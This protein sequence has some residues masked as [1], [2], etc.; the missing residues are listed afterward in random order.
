RASLHHHFTPVRNQ[1]K[2]WSR[3]TKAERTD[4]HRSQQSIG[5]SQGPPLRRTS[6]RWHW[7]LVNKRHEQAR[8]FIVDDGGIE[9]GHE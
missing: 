2:Q 8:S 4:V 1:E 7:A 3:K 9:Y 6:I 5:A